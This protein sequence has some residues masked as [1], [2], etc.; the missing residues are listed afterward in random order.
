MSQCFAYMSDVTNVKNRLLRMAILQSSATVILGACQFG[1]GILITKHGFIPPFWLALSVFFIAWLYVT[2]PGLLIET[3]DRN[4]NKISDSRDLK[5]SIKAGFKDLMNL[6][7][8]N[9]N[10]RRWR[11]GVLYLINFIRELL[12]SSFGIVLLYGLGPPFCWSPLNVSTYSI[13]VT[14]GSAIGKLNYVTYVI[15]PFCYTK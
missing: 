15:K 2:I 12:E 9:V 7:K 14:F 1:V 5:S 8:T 3:V 4:K 10:L 13:I 11:L 6:F